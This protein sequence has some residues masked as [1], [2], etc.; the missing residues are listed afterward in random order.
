MCSFSNVN[1]D[2]SSVHRA[3]E[4]TD[5]NGSRSASSKSVRPKRD[6]RRASFETAVN[7]ETAAIVC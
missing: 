6:A 2:G 7:F 1:S 3:G 4:S 5:G